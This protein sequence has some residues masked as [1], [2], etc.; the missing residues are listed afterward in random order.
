MDKKDV[1]ALFCASLVLWEAGDFALTG[2]KPPLPVG[3]PHIEF[4][5]WTQGGL[6]D[7]QFPTLG[8]ITTSGT[9]S[10][11]VNSSTFQMLPAG[12]L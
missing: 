4:P 7:A 3:Q 6:K 8:A 9:T 2:E 12:G 11:V 5:A 1:G 10:S